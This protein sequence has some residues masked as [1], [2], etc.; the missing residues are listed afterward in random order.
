MLILMDWCD[1]LENW[2]VESIKA[3]FRQW[4]RDNPSKKPNPGHILQI[5]NRAWG[6]RN[7]DKTRAAMA[8]QVQ[9]QGMTP[10]EHAAL[11]AELAEKFPG[12]IKS[13]PTAE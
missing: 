5:L 6:E 13:M 3:A 11:S 10:Q 8:Q 12:L 9:H 4:R 7:I 2:P 1:E